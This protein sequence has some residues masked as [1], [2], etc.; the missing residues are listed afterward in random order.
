[1]KL[2]IHYIRHGESCAN[3]TQRKFGVFHTCLRDP[4]L[5]HNG[6]E[7]TRM[8][9]LPEVDIVCS[10]TLKRAKRTARLSYPNRH[11]YILP[12]IQELGY[13]LDN[14][15]NKLCDQFDNFGDIAQFIELP[16]DNLC[17]DFMSYLKKYF[18][19]SR[20]EDFS[21]AMFTHQQKKK[22]NTDVKNSKNNEIVTKIYKF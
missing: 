18:L 9:S 5:T 8:S 15:P 20:S 3:A 19:K 10:S 4:D 17:E 16:C 1:M 13:G 6:T 21:I 22:K 7:S 12:G 2:T 14:I 11:I